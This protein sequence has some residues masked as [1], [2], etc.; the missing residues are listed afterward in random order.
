MP[1]TAA[2]A[3]GAGIGGG[4][5]TPLGGETWRQS[6][7]P[8][9]ES[10][11]LATVAGTRTWLAANALGY[12]KPVGRERLLAHG[13]DAFPAVTGTGGWHSGTRFDWT[14]QRGRALSSDH[15]VAGGLLIVREVDP[16]LTRR[17]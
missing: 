2:D 13:C 9:R 5:W 8:W 1:A 4:S 14:G 16:T 15:E 17:R 6:A 11:T 12:A 10:H 3:G 7:H